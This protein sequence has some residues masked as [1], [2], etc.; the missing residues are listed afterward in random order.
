MTTVVAAAVDGTVYMAADTMIN[1]YDRPIPGGARKI[2]RLP[3]GDGEVLIGVT[4][5][6]G[7]IGVVESLLK[8]DGEPGP[9]EDPQQW[10]F[11]VAKAV[12]ELAAEAGLYEDGRMDGSLLLGWKGRLWTLVHACAV[13]HHDGRTA[14]GSGEGP[15]IGALDALLDR[16]VPPETAVVD[17][18]HIGCKRD[19][20]SGL[21][22]QVELLP[23]R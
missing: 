12:T 3:A 18:V 1:V 23:G 4:G 8:I 15:A 9:D 19:R 6:G 2:V 13:P 14:L 5:S 17:A 16:D 22:I 20:F 21:P 10:A 7:L 11:T